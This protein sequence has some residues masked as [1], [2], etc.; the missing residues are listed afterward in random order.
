[1][2]RSSRSSAVVDI[3]SLC[4]SFFFSDRARGRRRTVQPAVP[5]AIPVRAGGYV[6]ANYSRFIVTSKA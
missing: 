2:R 4:M 3:V 6:C 5:R 1:M